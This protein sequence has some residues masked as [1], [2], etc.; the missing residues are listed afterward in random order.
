M[1]PRHILDE[2]HTRF[3]LRIAANLAVVFAMCA[4]A[5]AAHAAVYKCKDNTGRTTY[6][7]VPCGS[8]STPLQLHDPT[9]RSATDPHMCE[10][11]QDELNRLAKEATRNA[12]TGRPQDSTSANRRKTLTRQYEARCIGVSRSK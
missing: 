1:M 2:A 11:L 6:S 4:T 5:S 8:G 3:A 10:Q 12:K 7:D 9:S